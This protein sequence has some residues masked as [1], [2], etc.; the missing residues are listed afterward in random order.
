MK[1]CELAEF[2]SEVRAIAIVPRLLAKPL[3]DSLTIGSR[4]C[5]CCMSA[6]NPPPWTMNFG[7]TRWKIA[8]A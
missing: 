7:I 5:F 1:N 4:V 2:G 6:V 3:A 8:S